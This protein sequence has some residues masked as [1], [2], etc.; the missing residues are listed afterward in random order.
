VI[1]LVLLEEQDI[2]VEHL[3]E[4]LPKH[5]D[6]WVWINKDKYKFY[7]SYEE[8]IEDANN[9]G[10]IKGPVFI[11]EVKEGYQIGLFPGRIF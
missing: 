10:F 1:S 7:K 6:S 3:R 11:E 8:A 5:R 2:F 9:N 4:W